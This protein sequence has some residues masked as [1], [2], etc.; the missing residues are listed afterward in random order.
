[1]KFSFA[2][3]FLLSRTLIAKSGD[4]F[5]AQQNTPSMRDAMAVRSRPYNPGVRS[6]QHVLFAYLGHRGLGRFTLELAR[7]IAD[8][9]HVRATFCISRHHDILDR[10]TG[11]GCRVL[12]IDTLESMGWTFAHDDRLRALWTSIA[13]ELTRQR[14]VAM[15]TLMPHV[16]TPLLSPRVHGH[17][18]RYL[19]LIHDAAPHPRDPTRL[20]NGWALRDAQNADAVATLS[21]SV[22]DTLAATGAVPRQRIRPLFHPDL[23]PAAAHA[24]WRAHAGAP[25]RVLVLA[26]VLVHEG[27]SALVQAIAMLRVDGLNVE[28]GV[29]GDGPPLGPLRDRLLDLGAEVHNRWIAEHEVPAIFARYHALALC[30]GGYGQSAVAATALGAGMPLIGHLSEGPAEHVRD[31]VTGVV[32]TGTAPAEIAAA[33]RRLATDARLYAAIC[34]H[35]ERTA[36]ERSMRRFA[37]H[38]VAL[39]TDALPLPH[40]L[41]RRELTWV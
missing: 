22:A 32:A 35:I 13:G 24:E 10:L 31:G 37:E 18:V 41:P 3:I 6:T 28:L 38:L 8:M 11:S 34:A 33:I 14:S 27:L 39:A 30:H 36:W 40:G 12:P 16:W 26:P 1:L 29:L 17:N 19:T 25:F 5:T 2:R 23:K 4:Y 7:S 15:V 20:L 9:G 21:R